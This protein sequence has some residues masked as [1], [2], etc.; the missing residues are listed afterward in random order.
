M[1]TNC[2]HKMIINKTSAALLCWCWARKTIET[3]WPHSREQVQARKTSCESS[4]TRYVCCNLAHNKL[5][6]ML[7]NQN[8]SYSYFKTKKN[9]CCRVHS[10]SS[11]IAQIF[12]TN[13]DVSWLVE[14]SIN[15]KA[16]KEVFCD[17]YHIDS[18]QIRTSS[19]S[20]QRWTQAAAAIERRGEVQ[21]TLHQWMKTKTTREGKK[22]CAMSVWCG[23]VFSVLTDSLGG[24]SDT[25]KYGLMLGPN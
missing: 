17:W 24:F 15:T 8:F 3:T 18:I 23:E 11:P 1:V 7:T 4:Y 9:A 14:N 6:F 5:Q 22:M 25:S 21:W 2:V 16:D 10:M 19:H 20:K 13:I 12:R